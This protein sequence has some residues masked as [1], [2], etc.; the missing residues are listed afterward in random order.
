MRGRN[1]RSIVLVL[2]VAAG[3]PTWAQDPLEPPDI[4]KYLRWGPLRARP[5]IALS[6]LG[7]DDN[8]FLSGT[9]IVGDYT[10][11]VS[12]RLDGLVLFGDGPFLTFRE[13][14]D[15]TA[16]FS[17]SEQNYYDNR[18]VAKLTV[19]FRRFGVMTDGTLN[20]IRERPVDL[21]DIRPIRRETGLGAAVLV[22]PG[23]R[24]D[25]E[26]RVGQMAYE[27][28]DP[29]T[30][31]GDSAITRLSRDEGSLNLRL[32]YRVRGRTRLVF[33]G[34]RKTIDFDEPELIDGVPVARK[35]E[36]RRPMFGAELLTG[37]P[38]SG[39]LL[40]GW[41][42][43]DARDPQL[44]DLSTFV[45]EAHVVYRLNGRTRFEIDGVRLPGFSTF[46]SESYYLLTEIGLRPV[47]YF[48][49]LWGFEAGVRRGWLSFP[50]SSGVVERQDDLL[51]YDVGVR[52]R[53]MANSMGRRVEYWFR[54][55]RYNRDSNLDGLDR[56]QSTVGF[57][58]TA[59]F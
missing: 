36:E 23:W 53:V 15:Y 46:T 31:L 11:T 21:D 42:W 51:R 44:A 18:A 16:Y 45:S 54:V 55:G 2:A 19:P 49:R 35:T 5:G 12:P 13:Q 47:Y 10:A 7:Y 58:A 43:L 25:V 38:L 37:G 48:N 17:N 30:S 9:N 52:L 57:G 20:R 26:V 50:V 28:S 1:G 14:L 4:A 29:N 8:I 34:L 56:D 27:Y 32:K 24:T 6:N 3:A 33:D 40:V 41:D 59:G 39:T 22:R